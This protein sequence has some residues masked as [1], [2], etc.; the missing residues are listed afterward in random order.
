MVPDT[1]DANDPNDPTTDANTTSIHKMLIQLF[2]EAP[3]TDF[4]ST[5]KFNS[6]VKT[7]AL[8]SHHIPHSLSGV[9]TY[10]KLRNLGQTKYM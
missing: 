3:K 9:L 8:S 4:N 1:N 6:V 5:L 7:S 2:S 10:N